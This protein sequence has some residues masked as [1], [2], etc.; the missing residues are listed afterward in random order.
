MRGTGSLASGSPFGRSG[1]KLEIATEIWAKELA[2]T[3][4]TANIVNLERVNRPGTAAER[5]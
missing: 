3:G 4:V 5:R 1:V 2:R